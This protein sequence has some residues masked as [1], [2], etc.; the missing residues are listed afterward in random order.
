MIDLQHT[1]DIRDVVATEVVFTACR[2][3]EKR[4]PRTVLGWEVSFTEVLN[5]QHLVA[6]HASN[7]ARTLVATAMVDRFDC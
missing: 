7:T 1:D 5:G 3:N 2:S 6:I 4:E